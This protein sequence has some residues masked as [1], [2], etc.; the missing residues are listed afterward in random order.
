M[1]QQTQVERVL[2]K[3]AAFLER[4]PDV[5]A[6]ARAST[7]DVLRMW[8]G[9]GY[10]SRAL[11]LRDAAV[12]LVR[13]HGGTMPSQT[14][15]LRALPGVGA[16]TASAVRA[17]AFEEH[18]AAIDTNVRR[19]V[20]RLLYGLEYPA[21]VTNAV[22]DARARALVPRGK[23][24]AWNSAMMDLGA[25]VCSARAPKCMLC[26]MR[27]LCAAAPVD[28]AVLEHARSRFAR[29]RSPQQR[30]RFEESTRYVRGR[31]VD[32]LR[33]LPAGERV[34]LLDLLGAMPRPLDPEDF[35]AI[36]AALARDGLIAVAGGKVALAE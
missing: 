1:L 15:V 8:K 22:L 26:P 24:H 29:P 14:K 6:L 20:H 36:V 21:A 25:T 12:A 11:R 28:A 13:L 31:I 4:F 35:G 3:Y 32:R 10:N 30:V 7:A 18:D 27:A 9:L 2:P 5:C 16:Y 23:V 17:F 19:V 34:S 33:E